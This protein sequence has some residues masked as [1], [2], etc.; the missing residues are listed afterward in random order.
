MTTIAVLGGTGYAGQNIVREAVARGYS[1]VS[2]SRSLPSER[3]EGVEYR[4][5][6]F[7]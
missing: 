4:H 2:W 6:R 5:R 1:V 7:P 3:V